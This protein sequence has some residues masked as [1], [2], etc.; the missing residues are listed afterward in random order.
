MWSIA[1]RVLSDKWLRFTPSNRLARWGWLVKFELEMFQLMMQ[2]EFS[3]WVI[4][5]QNWI[6]GNSTGVWFCD[7]KWTAVNSVEVQAEK[8]VLMYPRIGMSTDSILGYEAFGIAS[9]AYLSTKN[10]VLVAR[11][12]VRRGS[13]CWLEVTG[14]WHP[15]EHWWVWVYPD[16]LER[17]EDQQGRPVNIYELTGFDW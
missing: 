5:K 15:G 10:I 8:L 6:L 1:Q 3:N 13:C 17:C 7:E 11:L 9:G 12:K 16:L 14:Q 2:F 4:E